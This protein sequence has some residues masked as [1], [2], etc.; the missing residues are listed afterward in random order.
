LYA[1][2]VGIGDYLGGTIRVSAYLLGQAWVS[3]LQLG[4]YFLGDYLGR[5]IDIGVINRLP[6]HQP[7]GNTPDRFREEIFLF[8]SLLNLSCCA[9]VTVVLETQGLLNVGAIFLTTAIAGGYALRVLPVGIPRSWGF[10]EFLHS[11]QIVVL[12]PALGLILQGGNFH[13]LLGLAAFPLFALHLAMQFILQFPTYASD[14]AHQRIT[15]LTRMGWENGIFIH[16]VLIIAAFLVLGGALFLGFPSRLVYP[17]L[18]TLP[19]AAF[20]V[21][22]MIRMRQGAPTRWRLQTLTA[23]VL[24]ILPAYLLTYSFWTQ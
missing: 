10:D 19:F 7:Q 14:L 21:W 8:A 18:L 5:S 4:F 9:V 20:Q 3:T 6:F 16:N 23:L 12:V 15:V 17:A 1:L 11:L 13:R 22:Y 2:G 24:F